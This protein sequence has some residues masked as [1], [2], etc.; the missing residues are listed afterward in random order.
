MK[1]KKDTVNLSCIIKSFPMIFKGKA[2]AKVKFMK[3]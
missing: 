1:A 3:V 2:Y